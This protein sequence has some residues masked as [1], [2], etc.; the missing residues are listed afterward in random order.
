M[1]V[2]SDT[3]P[4]N[5]LVLIE[6]PHILP[7]LFERIL[8]PHAVR[9][10]LR[11]AAAPDAIK[12][13]LETEP[14]WLE[15]RVVMDIDPTLRPLDAGEREA[16]AVALTAS[17]DLV[18]LDERKGRQAARE[19]GLAVS[20]TLGVIALAAQRGLVGMPD[21][22]ERL[23]GT[24]FRVSPRLIKYIADKPFSK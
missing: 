3:S 15:T 10:E 16:I 19:R 18:L 8:I 20:G 2:V 6:L 13:F 7:Q 9:Q 14:D 1:I 21:A 17:A 12:Q 4:L 11:S 5:Y 22:L 24:S 23:R